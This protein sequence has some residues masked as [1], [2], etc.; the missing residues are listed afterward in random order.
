MWRRN[1]SNCNAPSEVK[2]VDWLRVSQIVMNSAIAVGPEVA[3]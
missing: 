3:Y 1:D 2:G